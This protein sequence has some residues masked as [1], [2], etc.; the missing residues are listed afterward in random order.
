MDNSLLYSFK[1]KAFF[2]LP[3]DINKQYDE[4][5]DMQE[6]YRLDDDL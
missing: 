1:N 4:Y 2:C 3:S 5:T 6:T